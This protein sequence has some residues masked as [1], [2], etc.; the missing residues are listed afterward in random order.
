MD[1]G[2][3]PDGHRRHRRQR[4]TSR[5][6]RGADWVKVRYRETLIGLIGAVIGPITAPEALILGQTDDTGRL[7]ILGRSSPLSPSQRT[8]IGR[9]LRPPIGDHPWP[10]RIGSGQFGSAADITKVE[11][12][13]IAEVTA[14]TARMG[15]RRRHA[16]RFIRL[17]LD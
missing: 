4:T 12:E 5:Y 8:M 1:A 13:L 15:G 6:H 2:P 7:T 3:G 14:D 9:L 16:L 10:E 17:R 11:P